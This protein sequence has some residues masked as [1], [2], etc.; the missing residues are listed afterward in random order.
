M[1]YGATSTPSGTVA[2]QQETWA[3]DV[4]TLLGDQITPD[5]Q[6]SLEGWYTGEG[7]AGPEWDPGG[8]NIASY[9][10]LNST[11]KAAGSQNTPGNNPP[12]Q[13]YTNW[14]EGIVADVATLEENKPGYA[15]IRSDLASGASVQ[16]TYADIDASAWGT[17]D[18]PTSDVPSPADGSTPTSP[19]G[20]VSAAQNDVLSGA[21]SSA[22]SDVLS[23]LGLSSTGSDIAKVG[24]LIAGVVVGGLLIAAGAYKAISGTK[25]GQAVESDAKSAAQTGA[26]AAAA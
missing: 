17:H 11:L 12:V 24:V 26:M 10:P 3:D 2:Q 14:D 19:G 1:T 23:A 21:A 15:A 6:A 22:G 9:N 13:A 8:D 16:Q 4:L 7:G 20:D 18:L 5:A 25:A